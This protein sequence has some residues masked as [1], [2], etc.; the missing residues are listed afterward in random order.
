M[1]KYS[2]FI[3]IILIAAAVTSCRSTK[4][5]SEA[6]Q[7]KDTVAVTIT[8]PQ[9]EDTAK[10]VSELIQNIDRNKIEFNT[11]SAK[12]RVDYWNNKGK[13]P[14]FTANVRIKKDSLI[15]ISIGDL[16]FE[17]IRVLI[18]KD[19]IRLLNKL[20]NTYT[21]KPLSYVQEVSQIPF[22][23]MDIQDLLVGNL[24]FFNRDSITSYSKFNNSFSLLSVG[25]LFKN[26]VTINN[27]YHIE[28]SKLDDVNPLLNRTCDLTYSEFE[29]KSG[30]SFPVFREIF[31]SQQTK[32]DIQMKF[33]DYKFNE[34]LNF[35]FSIP[36]KFKRIQ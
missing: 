30:V 17:G 36:K 15:W 28:K 21:Q 7:K 3:A 13:Q 5:I 32:L 6:I 22:T 12:I 23:F 34:E 14:D 4:K 10:L 1:K 2:Y 35:P 26:L 18:T 27:E 19:S 8:M 33:K 25:A 24:I 16:G 11:F 20:E 29:N 9:R 31:I